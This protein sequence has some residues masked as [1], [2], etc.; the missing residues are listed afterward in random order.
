MPYFSVIIPLFNKEKYIQKTLESVLK[1]SFVDFEVIIVNDGSTD[2][3]E[4]IIKQFK[5]SRIRY[6]KTKNHG[7][8]HARNIGIDTAKADYIAF[9]DADDLWLE[10]HL[11][12]LKNLINEFPNAG[13]Y[14]SRYQLVYKNNSFS[15]PKFNG[16]SQ[17]FKGYLNDYFM[18]TQNN[19]LSLT[20]V[21]VIPKS[22]FNIVGNFNVFISSGQDIDMWIRIALQYPIVI[23][24]T[25]TA[26]Y[27]EYI[28]DSLSK[29]NILQK[30]L[31][32][33][34]DFK[35]AENQNPSLKKYLDIYRMEYALQYKIV[36][37]NKESKV[38]FDAILKENI[39]LKS[40][41]LYQL[42]QLV[43]V[44]L[45]QLKRFLRKYGFDFSV[46]Q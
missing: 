35:Q 29:T 26:S 45:L 14:A 39:P 32:C 40:K 20:L 1:Q 7:A 16:I 4:A 27:L 43:L 42:P 18:A 31:I 5:D 36:G 34:E 9:I 15:I 6:F 33:F 10:N 25:V 28:D 41:V 12:T 19:S 3:S 8:A 37:A 46:Y 13:I 22:V 30:K 2:G 17:D 24:N 38:L 21:N 11:E 23:G 44:K